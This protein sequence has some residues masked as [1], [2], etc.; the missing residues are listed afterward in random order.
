M[1]TRT[2]VGFLVALVTSLILAGATGC[3]GSG[4]AT[5]PGSRDSTKVATRRARRARADTLG[6]KARGTVASARRALRGAKGKRGSV[7]TMSPDEVAQERKRLREEKRRLREELRRK[8]REERLAQRTLGRRAKRTGSKRSLYDAYILKATIAG[9]Y[10]LIGSRR[11]ERGDVIAGKKLVEVGSDRIVL[12][13]F[14]NRFGVRIG[15]P[16]E[17]T[18]TGQGRKRRS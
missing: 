11:L 3:G 1:S 17:R 15:E 6:G 10:A 16:V 18:L 4:A 8:R 13:Q 14:G 7:K 12:E 2:I 9:R 5:R